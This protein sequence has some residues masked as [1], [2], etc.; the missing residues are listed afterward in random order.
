MAD[1]ERRVVQTTYSNTGKLVRY[2]NGETVFLPRQTEP[3]QKSE[4]V[5]PPF[6]PDSGKIGDK[7]CPHP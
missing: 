2:D 1:P 3:D 6:T 4:T 7:E 5:V